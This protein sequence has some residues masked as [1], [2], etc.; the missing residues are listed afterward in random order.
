M[1]CGWAGGGGADGRGAGGQVKEIDPVTQLLNQ[2]H[3]IVFVTQ[4]PPDM[5][6]RAD[7][8]KFR[9]AVERYKR[10]LFGRSA[11]GQGEGLLL[12][13]ELY[14]LM[15]SSDDTIQAR[16]ARPT[17]CSSQYPGRYPSRCPSQYPCRYPSRVRVAHCWNGRASRLAWRHARVKS[18]PR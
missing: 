2:L 5:S 9:R 7:H 15:T 6:E 18:H 8:A 11:A 13:Q 3:K 1:R 17:P 10:A 16:P 14:K 4:L 12:K